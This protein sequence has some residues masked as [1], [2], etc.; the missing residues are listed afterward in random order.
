MSY[1]AGAD[2]IEVTFGAGYDFTVSD[3]KLFERFRE[4]LETYR[5]G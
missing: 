3:D 1:N 4:Q 2:L 5:D